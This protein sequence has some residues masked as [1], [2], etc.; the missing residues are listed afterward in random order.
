MQEWTHSIK[1]T[2]QAGSALRLIL[3]TTALI[4]AVWQSSTLT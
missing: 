3:Y 1:E 2:L 4:L